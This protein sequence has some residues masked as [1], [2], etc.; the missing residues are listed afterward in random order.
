M[1]LGPKQGSHKPVAAPLQ[2]KFSVDHEGG[3]LS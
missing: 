3:L 1:L 2:D